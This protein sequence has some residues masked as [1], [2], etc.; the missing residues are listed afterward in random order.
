M[1]RAWRVP[2][3]LLLPVLL[4]SAVAIQ[5]RTSMTSNSNLRLNG[6]VPAASP[7]GALSS[8]WYCAAGSAT[9]I[10]TGETAGFAEQSIVVS[11]ATS[12]DSTGAVSVFTEKGD[13]S[14]PLWSRP[15][16]K[17]QFA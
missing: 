17:Q 11:N 6:M 10:T 3:L 8:T 13:T 4:V 1:K 16:V 7:E 14:K 15:I 12:A 5:N 9:G 2:I